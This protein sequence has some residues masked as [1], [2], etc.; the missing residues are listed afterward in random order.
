MT[1]LLRSILPL[2]A[3]LALALGAASTAA[4]A[5]ATAAETG[6]STAT[7][8][9]PP[10]P[11]SVEFTR[12]RATLAGPRALVPVRC[13]GQ[14]AYTCEGTLVLRGVRG[15]HKVPYSI[16]RGESR[17]L[18]VPL[19]DEDTEVDPGCKARVVARTLQLSGGTVRTS[20]VLRIG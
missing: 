10:A 6:A 3:V 4:A 12:K 15:S 16:E 8:E 13:G 19:G 18:A 7:E 1:R 5:E 20:S 17:I 9:A 2:L 14:A 11:M